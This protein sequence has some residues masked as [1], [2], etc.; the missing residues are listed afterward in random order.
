MSENF[1]HPNAQPFLL[2][3]G[4]DAVLL[5]HG[6]TGSPAHMRTVGEAIN[7]AGFTAKG[8]LLPGHGGRLRTW[9]AQTTGNG[10]KRAARRIGSW[11]RS[12]GASRLRGFRWAACFPV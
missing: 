5:I 7:G 4:E 10:A 11:R 8:I 12:T 9:S 1:A 6:F 3:G 2:E